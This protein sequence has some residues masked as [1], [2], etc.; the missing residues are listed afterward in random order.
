[1]TGDEIKALRR[2]LDLTARK[3][4]EAIGVDQATVLAW[5]REELF[6]TRR[7][8]EAMRGLLENTAE[9]KAGAKSRGE[10][11]GDGKEKE[12][13]GEDGVWREM[14]D[15]EVWRLF[16][17]VLAF[18]ELRAEVMRLAERYPDPAGD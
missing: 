7:H 2:A 15:P 17:K 11:G 5:E 8:V 13:S 3:L 12:K 6:P 16:R 10:P 14:A 1:M 18:E 9:E 4:G